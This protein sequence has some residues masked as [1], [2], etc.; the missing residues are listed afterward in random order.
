MTLLSNNEMP[1]A[2]NPAAAV[3]GITNFDIPLNVK[4]HRRVTTK[5]Y[6]ELYYCVPQDLFN[7][8]EFFNN[9]ATEF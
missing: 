1:F 5:L 3:D 8:L 2:L 6:V 4:L 7:F 9:R